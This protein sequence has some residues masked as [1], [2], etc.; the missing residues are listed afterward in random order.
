MRARK[1]REGKDEK[2]RRDCN[3]FCSRWFQILH[4]PNVL[5]L[6]TYTSFS[7][8]VFLARLP[9]PLTRDM[10]AT[11]VTILSDCHQSSWPL[12]T[13]LASFFVAQG[14]CTDLPVSVLF[15][16]EFMNLDLQWVSDLRR[17]RKTTEGICKI[18]CSGF[19]LVFFPLCATY[20]KIFIR[21]RRVLRSNYCL[22]F[23]IHP[24]YKDLLGNLPQDVKD[25]RYCTIVLN[26]IAGY[27]SV[28][29]TLCNHKSPTPI[30]LHCLAWL[31]TS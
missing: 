16:H 29:I 4:P 3:L 15:A 5:I 25:D 19:A 12:H 7:F 10:L 17:R 14:L 26:R 13:G 18:S 28:S 22:S 24:R 6:S 11:L 23:F 2:R 1:M 9:R 21:W 31:E 20:C 27:G 8:C 30:L